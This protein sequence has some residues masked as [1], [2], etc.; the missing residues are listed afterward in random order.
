VFAR[1]W[2]L[3]GMR[4]AAFGAILSAAGLAC[5]FATAIASLS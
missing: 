5:Y 1:S 4:I 3:R 2:R